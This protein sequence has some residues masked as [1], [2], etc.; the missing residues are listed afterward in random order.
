MRAFLNALLLTLLLGLLAVVGGMIWLSRPVTTQDVEVVIKAGSLVSVARQLEVQGVTV[1]PQ[2]LYLEQKWRGRKVRAGT[3]RIPA[4]ANQYGVY[5][6]LA[7]GEPVMGQVTVPEGWTVA[8]MRRAVDALPDV[9]HVSAHW[10]EAQLAQALGLRQPL[11]GWFFPETYRYNKG[12]DDLVIYRLAYDKMRNELNAVW[13]TREINLPLPD[14]YAL[15]R[16]ASIVEKESGRDEDRPLVA[17]VLLNRLR[18][19]M[20]LQSDPTVIYGLGARYDGNLRK[21]DLTT[22]TSFNTYTR[23]GLTPTPIALPGRAALQS[24]AHPASSAALYFVSRGDGSSVF[25]ETLTQ[26]NQAV[27][28]YQRNAH[29]NH[30]VQP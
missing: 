4:Q 8:Q 15:L 26:H 3:F 29:G 30:T 28:Q 6:A 20:P 13:R 7:F 16:L 2:L 23:T 1:W 10:G 27:N 5:E 9:V 17:A 21:V 22:D 12:D 25:S 19:G 18:L 24:V 11:E 14:A